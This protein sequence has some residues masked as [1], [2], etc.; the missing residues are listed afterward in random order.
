MC[1]LFSMTAN[2]EAIL[3]LFGAAHNRAAAIESK[4]GIFPGHNAPVVRCA[5]GGER[6]L[7]NFSWGFILPQPGKAPRRF[8]NT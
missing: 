3:R 8:T 5:E 1:N 7:F 2:R 6:E 4:D